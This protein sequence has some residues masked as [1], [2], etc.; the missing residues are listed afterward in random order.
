MKWGIALMFW[1]IIALGSIVIYRFID[2]AGLSIN[3][4]SMYGIILL[5]STLTW[6]GVMQVAQLLE[7]TK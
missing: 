6:L 2:V 3:S 4:W 5:I 7:V 1:I